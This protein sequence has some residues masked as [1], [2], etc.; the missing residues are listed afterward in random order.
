MQPHQ[1]AGHLARAPRLSGP[2]LPGYNMP[3]HKPLTLPKPVRLIRGETF[4]HSGDAIV[5]GPGGGWQ[6]LP[7]PTPVLLHC[8]YFVVQLIGLRE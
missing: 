2:Q 1:V 3:K 7:I 8:S 5:P 6:G 4:P